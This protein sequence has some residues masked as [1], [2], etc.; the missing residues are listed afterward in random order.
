[1]RRPEAHEAPILPGVRRRKGLEGSDVE[2]DQ[3]LRESRVH[4]AR[5]VMTGAVQRDAHAFGLLPRA[6]FPVSEPLQYVFVWRPVTHDVEP[7]GDRPEQS[8]LLDP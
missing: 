3:P 6:I 2:R 8:A 1:M 5:V 7:D 4:L